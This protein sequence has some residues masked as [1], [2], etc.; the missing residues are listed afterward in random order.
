[1]CSLIWL[2]SNSAILWVHVHIYM[3]KFVYAYTYVHK[4]SLPIS[5]GRRVRNDLVILLYLL[6]YSE[7][8]FIHTGLHTGLSFEYLCLAITT[9]IHICKRQSS[10][11]IVG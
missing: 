11:K 3:Y 1:M 4:V 6:L 8:R 7:K 10:K 5:Y 2:R 9:Y